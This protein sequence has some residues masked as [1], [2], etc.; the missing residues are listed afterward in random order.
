MNVRRN[1]TPSPVRT[2]LPLIVPHYGDVEDKLA[3]AKEAA[4][5]ALEDAEDA[6]VQAE[7]FAAEGLG[8]ITD[9]RM[10]RRA[11]YMIGAPLIVYVGLTNDRFPML[12]KLTALLGV[13]IGLRNYQA[14]SQI[15]AAEVAAVDELS[16]YGRP[17]AYRGYRYHPHRD[18]RRCFPAKWVNGKPRCPR[19]ARL[20]M[21]G[22]R[23]VCCR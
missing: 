1:P 3:E 14:E 13:F 21:R 11:L 18:A 8:K 20:R 15:E 10:H 17:P 6:L 23:K 22:G 16:G 12:G 9:V 19:G 2:G 7:E 5:D 4:A